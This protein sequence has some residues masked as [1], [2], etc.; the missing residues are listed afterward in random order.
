MA[1]ITGKPIWDTP[2]GDLGTIQ[3]GKFYQLT[4]YAH[5]DITNTSEHL[6]YIMVAGELPEGIQCLEMV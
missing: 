2:A 1:V 4:L 5:D 3:E 6:Y